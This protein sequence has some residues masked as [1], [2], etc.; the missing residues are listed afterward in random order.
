M[1]LDKHTEA[2]LIRRLLAGDEQAYRQAVASY[3]PSMLRLAR[4]MLDWGSAE[5]VVQDTWVA[6]LRGLSGFEA[7]ASLKTWL[8]TIVRHTA[9]SRLRRSGRELLIGDG[10]DDDVLAQPADRF[11]NRG[12]W[13][14]PP[15][16]WHEE[17]PEALLAGEQLRGVLQQALEKL[18]PPQRSAVTLRDVEGL[19]MD[20]LCAVLGVTQANA[21]VLLH[22]GRSR[23]REAVASY[24]NGVAAEVP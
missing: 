4:A 11:D 9:L 12:H 20:A 5:E 6:V 16:P 14:A 24:Q 22:R 19:D 15:Q 3:Q 7:R 17:T 21:R 13:Q 1:P 10:W 18:P 23:L 2:E 8:L